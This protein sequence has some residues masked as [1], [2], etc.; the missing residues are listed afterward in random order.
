MQKIIL[1]ITI[2]LFS[3]GCT[4]QQKQKP[5]DKSE[6]VK[7]GSNEVKTGRNT[8]AVIWETPNIDL[9]VNNAEVISQE[10]TT[11][12]E[13]DVIE[14]AYFDAESVSE[15]RHS[16]PNVA[17]FLKAYSEEEAIHIL[18]KLT[19]VR[20]GIA[21][22][23]M[24]PVGMLWLPRNEAI[25]E[26]SKSYV[27][28]WTDNGEEPEQD[29]LKQQYDQILSLWKKGIIEN[30]YF[31]IE[32]LSSPNNKTDFVFFVN[33]PGKKEAEAICKS[34]PFYQTNFSTFKLQRV[35]VFWF[36]RYENQ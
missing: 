2:A 29:V 23:K 28:V 25:Q 1:L 32:K 11:L 15:N 6:R 30:V 13:N 35:G 34:L 31:N 18:E 4:G 26:V 8:Y 17:F 12:Y 22:Y 7:S 27:A 24:Y 36:G 10:F 33:A 9:V 3:L 5:D 19:I 16:F 14:N 21:T 20:K